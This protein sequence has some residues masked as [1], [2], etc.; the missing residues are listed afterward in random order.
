[1]QW[2]ILIEGRKSISRGKGSRGV[3]KEYEEV[4]RE[5]LVAWRG[6]VGYE[7]FYVSVLRL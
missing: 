1:V 7:Y 4:C 6:L 5:G 2:G 3:Q